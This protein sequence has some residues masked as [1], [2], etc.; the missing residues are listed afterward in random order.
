VDGL[1]DK[2]TEGQLVEMMAVTPE[3]FHALGI[4]LMRGRGFT[5]ADLENTAGVLRKWIAGHPSGQDRVPAENLQ[6]VALI[7]QTMARRFWPNQDAI[8]KTYRK[9]GVQIQVIG[10][11]G[12]TKVF[13]LRQSPIP[14]TYYPL[15]WI[16]G[17]GGHTFRIV[18]QTGGNPLSAA[19]TARNV[20]KS[21]DGGLALYQV[22]TMTDIT[23][24]TMAN[25][26][27][28]TFLLGTFAAF[29]LI[30]AAIGTYGV[31]SYLVTQR[32]GEIGIRMALGAARGAMLLMILRQGLTLAVIGV[33]IG[34]A[35]ALATSKLL[36]SLLFGVKPSDPATLAGV[37]V[38]MIAVT[39]M[40][41]IIPAM[42]AMRIEPM[43]ALR[44]E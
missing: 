5:D 12:D 37:S 17:G 23:A 16:T 1:S 24:A 39:M 32:T 20:V 25:D 14:Q 35:A 6:A 9:D 8:G 13:G 31:M 7:N 29:A 42:R 43:I 3:Y 40:A 38:L 44:H 33:G 34:L 10:I 21:L 28:Q 30:L 2:S 11:V 18:V 36:A 27:Q 4:P 19:A 41:C 15:T 26:S 22:Q